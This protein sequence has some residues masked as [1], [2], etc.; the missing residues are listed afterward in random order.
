MW[1]TPIHQNVR[2]H[3]LYAYL[4]LFSWQLLILFTKDI[5]FPAGWQCLICFKVLL[6][7]DPFH[8]LLYVR[9]IWKRLPWPRLPDCKYDFIVFEICPCHLMT[10]KHISLHSNIITDFAQIL[11][12]CLCIL[13][14]WKFTTSWIS[15]S[16]KIFVRFSNQLVQN[17]W[18]IALH[19]C[20]R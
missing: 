7:S 1:C 2:V 20:D 8:Q 11:W 3:P 14:S 18:I 9:S 6:T 12:V 19:V 17:L 5:L 15:A 4:C 10:M 13:L 16:C